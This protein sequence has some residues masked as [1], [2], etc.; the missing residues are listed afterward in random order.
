MP[1]E[2]GQVVQ[3][4]SPDPAPTTLDNVR[5]IYQDLD[6]SEITQ[7]KYSYAHAT[8][9]SNVTLELLAGPPSGPFVL[10]EQHRV[11]LHGTSMKEPIMSLQDRT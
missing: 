3:T 5:G 6:S 9:G 7:F 2:G 4:L 11:Y 8:R 1:Y 10:L